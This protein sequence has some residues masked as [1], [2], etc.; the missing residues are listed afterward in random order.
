MDHRQPLVHLILTQRK[1]SLPK[2]TARTNPFHPTVVEDQTS[3][4]STGRVPLAQTSSKSTGRVELA[5]MSGKNPGPS[6]RSERLV[7]HRTF[8]QRSKF[9]PRSCSP[10]RGWRLPAP[11]CRPCLT[12]YCT[13][14]LPSGACRPHCS[15][16]CSRKT[17]PS[18]RVFEK[19]RRHVVCATRSPLLYKST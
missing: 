5:R 16:R 15:L 12:Q 2:R 3:S 11:L 8:P 17:R 1:S 7:K 13:V 19:S 10:L 9:T 4:N 14:V 6:N 18:E